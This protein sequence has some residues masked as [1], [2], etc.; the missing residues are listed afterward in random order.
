MRPIREKGI[1]QLH[2]LLFANSILSRHI[3]GRHPKTVK[4]ISGLINNLPDT[5]NFPIVSNPL[6]ESS[7]I[8]SSIIIQVKKV[9]YA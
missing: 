8:G 3:N 4:K 7:L 9:N 1:S 6:S 2:L 5:S